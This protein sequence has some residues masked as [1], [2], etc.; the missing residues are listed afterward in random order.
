[1]KRL[2]LVCAVI[3][4]FLV[5]E[6]VGQAGKSYSSGGSSGSRSSSSGSSGG[7]RS[8]SSGG[9]SGS[10]GKSYSSGSGSSGSGKSYSSGSGSSGKSYSSGSG[11]SGSGSSGKSYS[12]GSGSSGKSYS[13][14]STKPSGGDSKPSTGSSWFG[15]SNSGNKPSADSPSG[16]KYSSGGS[17]TSK[18]SADSPSGKKYSSGGSDTSK[19][20]ADSPSGKKYSSSDTKKV[21]AKDESHKPKSSAFNSDLSRAAKEE[22]SKIAYKK[23]TEPKSDYKAPDGKTVKIDA[24]SHSTKVVRDLPPERVQNH[25]VIVEKHYHNYYG[26]RY[27]YYRSQ[28]YIYVGGGYSSLFWYAMLDWDMERR[29]AWMY[30]HQHE[31]DSQLW[32]QQMQNADLRARVTQLEREKNGVRDA[33]YVDKD[34]RDNPEAQ[35]DTAYVQNAANLQAVEQPASD[36]NAGWVLLWVV[37]GTV[38][39][40]L[41]VYF[42]FIKDYKTE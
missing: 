28:P 18:P 37:L 22:E 9:S 21:D 8:Y 25:T 27:D 6:V 15:G 4:I 39:V 12:S 20:S 40:G 42:V 38:A 14:G 2:G 36:S 17:D 11:S 31:I 41:V 10:S 3:A 5:G 19:P 1:M 33:N 24:S 29:A 23:A 13:G 35:Y 32:Q 30:H 7:S 34:F 16:K 26:P